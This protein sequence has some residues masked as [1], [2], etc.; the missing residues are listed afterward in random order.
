MHR[1][2]I[3]TAAVTGAVTSKDQT[4]YLPVTPEEIATACLESI[5]AGASIAH[6]HVRDPGTGRPSMC[7]DLY[8]SVVDQIKKHRPDA[9]INL[10]TGPGSTA[11]V[12]SIVDRENFNIDPKTF[13]K[14]AHDRV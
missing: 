8:R 3:I 4:P 10:T 5:E 12:S 7:V 14:Q 2:T 13:F 1:P 9:I 11:P 6:I